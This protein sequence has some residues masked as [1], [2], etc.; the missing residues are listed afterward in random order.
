M[1]SVLAKWQKCGKHGCRC[2]DGILHGPYF[3]LVTYHSARSNNPRA[4]KYSWRYLGSSPENAWQKL[5]KIDSRFIRRYSMSGLLK[6]LED[7]I[8]KRENQ[9]IAPHSTPLLTIS[10]E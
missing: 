1:A 9:S 10:D 5:N 4:G 7:I 8:R 3:W 6:K 2:N